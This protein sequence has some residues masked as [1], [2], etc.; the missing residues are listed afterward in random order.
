MPPGNPAGYLNQG[1]GSSWS[2]QQR[3]PYQLPPR[4]GNPWSLQSASRSSGLGRGG[5]Y[6]QIVD[7]GVMGGPDHDSSMSDWFVPQ[8]SQVRAPV[9]GTVVSSGSGFFGNVGLSIQGDDG[10][11]WEMR[12]VQGSVQPGT[13]VSAG[14]PVAQVQ[15]PSLPGGWQHVDIRRNG[16]GATPYLRQAGAQAQV[17]PTGGPSQGMGFL[18]QP[19]PNEGGGGG[20]GAP[21]GGFGPFGGGGMPG[22]FGGMGGGGGMPMMGGPFGGMPGGGMPGMG[23]GMPGGMGMGPPGMGGGP[24]GGMGRPPMMGGMGGP[25]GGGRPPGPGMGGMG[26]PFG[27]PMGMG[28]GMPPP[29]MMG[30]PFGMG[31]PGGGGF[32]G[33]GFGGGR[34][35]M[36]P[37]GGPPPMMPPMMPGMGGG[38]GRMPF[39]GGG[40][41]M[42]VM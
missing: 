10:A 30:G 1:M 7:G 12:H 13:R 41:Q 15:D 40:F 29:P 42:P 37:F 17:R 39:G 23:M 14:Q 24:F 27:G 32:G 33:P 22:P 28:M 31:M 3:N 2:T 16:Q 35:P 11:L 8:G 18:M 34:P 38:F 26:M 6:A 5:L 36:G 25:F 9:S 19:G 21:G 20:G 4:E